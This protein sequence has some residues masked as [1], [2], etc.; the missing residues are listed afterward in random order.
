LSRADL[1]SKAVGGG[2]MPSDRNPVAD[3]SQARKMEDD[4][5]ESASALPR[6]WLE[7][8]GNLLET[9]DRARTAPDSERGRYVS[10][11]TAVAT[12]ISTFD[13][14][15]GHRFFDLASRLGD[16]DKGRDEDA[17]FIPKKIWDRHVEASRRWRGRARAILAIEAL[18]ATDVKPGKALEIIADRFPNLR[19]L[20][21]PKASAS[22]ATVL[23]N[24]RKEFSSGRVHV[25]NYEAELL[26][27]E[28]LKRIKG[29]KAAGRIHEILAIADNADIAASLG[30]VLSASSIQQKRSYHLA[31]T[32]M[33][34]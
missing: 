1:S 16:L 26:Y 5:S 10:E 23:R 8:F 15:L 25:K 11:L 32:A 20:A 19:E 14:K 21:G 18:I 28:G 2:L 29:L 34:R 9:L 24:W 3:A 31:D 33:R 7:A 17:L 30:G 6:A 27:D 12:F 13:K 4:P 22:L